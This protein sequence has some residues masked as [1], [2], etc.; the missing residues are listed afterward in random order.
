MF[1]LSLVFFCV[2]VIII[3]IL[4]S[5]S[6]T[7]TSLLVSYYLV[8]ILPFLNLVFLDI[9]MPCL[10]ALI[11]VTIV[12]IIYS[13]QLPS[14]TF[15]FSKCMIITYTVISSLSHCRWSS[16][17]FPILHLLT[18]HYLLCALQYSILVCSQFYLSCEA[19]ALYTHLVFSHTLQYCVTSVWC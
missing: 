10:F 9:V 5:S 1:C 4:T 15:L 11:I 2:I 14:Y 7:A 12:S 13:S 19:P 17:H 3:I 16:P 8:I 6:T 18:P